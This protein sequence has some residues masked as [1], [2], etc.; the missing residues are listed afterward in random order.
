MYNP[1]EAEIEK[2][3]KKNIL[4]AFLL[5]TAALVC[6]GQV[7]LTEYPIPTAGSSPYF[8]TAGPE[9]NIWF[10]EQSGN[11][12]ARINS[13]GIVTEFPVTTAGSAPTGIA[14]GPDGNLWFTE[15][16][17][18][19][20]GKMTTSGRVLKEYPIPTAFS[21][22]AGITLGPDGN[23]WFTELGGNNIG[24]ITTNG[25]VTEFPIPTANSQAYS[26][27][28]G[29][30]G[31]LWFAENLANQIGKFSPLT[32]KFTEYPAPSSATGSE[33]FGIAVGSDHNLWY[34]AGIG[35][36]IGQITTAG[37]VKQFPMTF[38]GLPQNSGPAGI[39]AGPDGNLW[40]TQSSPSPVGNLIGKITTSGVVSEYTIETLN[41]GPLGITAG[42][43]GNLW[44]TENSGNNIGKL[45]PNPPSA[46]LISALTISKL[47]WGKFT[48]PANSVVWVNA[49]I[50]MPTGIPTN[51]VSNLLFTGGSLVV[52]GTSYQ[53]PNGLITFDPGAPATPSTT[54]HPELNTWA[55]TVNPNNT[56][57][58]I[59]VAG[60]ALPVGDNLADGGPATVSFSV[61]SSQKNLSFSWQWGAAAYKFWPADWNNASIQ[62][63]QN[64]NFQAGTPLHAKVQ[65][66]LIN[67][68]FGGSDYIGDPGITGAASC[69]GH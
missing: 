37:V 29:P 14:A 64:S 66:S 22:P 60:A 25:V 44:F 31:N 34:T 56:G 36:Y 20:I 53:L 47:A 33:P 15:A 11:N 19:N 9:G 8:I 5:F 30:D 61:A 16:V 58:E 42:L 65:Q 28:T 18:N 12:I 17:G 24:R 68:P 67:G 32:H 49:H 7:T 41:S 39:A 27:T 45:Q 63:Y 2:N 1:P 59:F 52:N 35:N 55:T 13:Q 43:D 26:I 69:I 57:T 3:M 40:F 50:A 10:T 51:T 46:C 23:L 62:P 38:P 4:G 6:S 54:F 48:P 21:F